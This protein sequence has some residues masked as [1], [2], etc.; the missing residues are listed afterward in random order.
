MASLRIETGWPSNDL[1]P[2][3]RP[4]RY[5]KA[6]AIRRAKAEGYL[7]TASAKPLGF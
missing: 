4:N 5:A 2:N 6:R 1:S 7:A 3:G